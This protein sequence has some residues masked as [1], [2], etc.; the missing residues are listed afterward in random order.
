M[1][2]R[3]PGNAEAPLRF[4]ILLVLASLV[5]YVLAFPNPVDVK[6]WGNLGWVALAPL[7]A[8]LP[9]LRPRAA[10][11]VG[12]FYGTALYA[13][14]N[15]WLA[16]YH[17]AALILACAYAAFGMG[18]LFPFISV[19]LRAFPRAGWAAV[20]ALWLAYEFL[21]SQGFM[22]YPYCVLGYAFW[23]DPAMLGV[24]SLG[25]VW[26]VSLS[27]L[28]VN[29]ALGRVIGHMLRHKPPFMPDGNGR[30]KPTVSALRR[31]A[32]PIAIALGSAAASL[33]VGAASRT[34]WEPRDY[35][36]AALVQPNRRARQRTL[37]DYRDMAD[38]LIRVTEK[39]RAGNPD[40]I[41]WHETAI[42]PPRGWHLRFRQDRETLDLVVMVDRYI[43]ELDVPL[44]FGNS[45]AE[46]TGPDL[47]DRKDWNS[48]FLYS[49]GREIGR[50]DKMRLVPYS[51]TFPLADELPRI[52][53]AIK[54]EVGRF[55]EPGTELTVFQLGDA[56]FSAPICFE[57]SFGDL[58]RAMA[59]AGADFLV[60]LTDDSWARSVSMQY[61]HLGQ[62]ALRAAELGIPVARAANTGSTSLLGPDGLLLSEL[63]PF[64]E[65]FL[66]VDIPLPPASFTGTL[67]RRIGDAVGLASLAAA[68]AW[69]AAALAV[70]VRRRRLGRAAY[71]PD[72]A[73]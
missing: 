48:A 47:R 6:G 2:Q 16:T 69:I 40:L 52:A 41:V 62:S 49:G 61:H 8:V 51:E 11:L 18:I 9:N 37:A 19:V 35:L 34:D 65:G 36:R 39:A 5:L 55:W 12:A 54:E 10:A 71:R 42:V 68:A 58:T 72:S 67:Y 17:P 46:P 60:V 70:A 20:P 3:P 1:T 26:L 44:L 64:T 15:Y 56:R 33:A 4:S 24:A 43:R 59:A 45:R 73:G 22:G 7:F 25:G 28:T 27:A 38:R 23:R 57:D 66:E 21:R 32:L 13:L 14:S 30:L 53:A 50:Y 29:A 31:S 63:P